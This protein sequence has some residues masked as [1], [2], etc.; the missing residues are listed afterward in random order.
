[1]FTLMGNVHRFPIDSIM[2]SGNAVRNLSEAVLRAHGGPTDD[3][4]ETEEDMDA[5]Q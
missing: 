5:E 3:Y 2:C 1:M 4:V